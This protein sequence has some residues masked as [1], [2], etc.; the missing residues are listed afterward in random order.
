[1]DLELIFRRHAGRI[2]DRQFDLGHAVGERD[3]ALDMSSAELTFAEDGTAPLVFAAVPI[4]TYSE[5]SD[6]WWWADTHP[7]IDC[8]RERL[9][10][11]SRIR[12]DASLSELE[13]LAA[14]EV[15]IV[16]FGFSSIGPWDLAF[17]AGALL[18]LPV[19]ACP[20]DR[21]T[22][23]VGVEGVPSSG[24]IDPETLV[25][26]FR[27]STGMLA[28]EKQ[29]EALRVYAEHHGFEVLEDAQG[30]QIG[31]GRVTAFCDFD[32]DFAQ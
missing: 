20:N 22:L 2:T 21:G 31:D 9:E 5:E 30:L 17:L 28:F 7:S 4:G 25:D 13:E 3:W 19:Y 6:T 16:P 1:M 8:P 12:A 27:Q 29:R 32:G 24:A 23:F 26:R 18:E 14:D 10:P 11:L 15:D